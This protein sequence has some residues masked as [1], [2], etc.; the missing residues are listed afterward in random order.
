MN[1]ISSYGLL[2][3]ME[4]LPMLSPRQKKKDTIKESKSK[5]TKVLSHI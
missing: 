1:K 5:N 3:T 4:T 2:P